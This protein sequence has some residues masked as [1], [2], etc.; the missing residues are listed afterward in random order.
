MSYKNWVMMHC[1]LNGTNFGILSL[2]SGVTDSTLIWDIVS[3]LFEL[4]TLCYFE[5]RV[6]VH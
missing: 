3:V 6:P 4:Q 1:V 5:I 2:F